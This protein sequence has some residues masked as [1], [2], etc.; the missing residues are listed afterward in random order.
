MN[1]KN[2]SRLISA[3]I[4]NYLKYNK[5]DNQLKKFKDLKV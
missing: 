1:S 4:I 2:T 5:F 3:S